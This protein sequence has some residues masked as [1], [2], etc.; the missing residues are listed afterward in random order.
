MSV[1]IYSDKAVCVFVCSTHSI[2][3]FVL[4]LTGNNTEVGISLSEDCGRVGKGKGSEEEQE[5]HGGKVMG[6]RGVHEEGEGEVRGS[7]SGT[8]GRGMKPALWGNKSSW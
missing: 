8:R 2:Q 3:F 6:L 7:V 5:E 4:A 1:P